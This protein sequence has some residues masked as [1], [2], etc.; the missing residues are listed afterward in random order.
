ML[1]L[2]G[3]TTAIL[4][5]GMGGRLKTKGGQLAPLTDRI[6]AYQMA[7]RQVKIA[8]RRTVA[9]QIIRSQQQ[10]AQAV[11]FEL[12]RRTWTGR[13][14]LAV[15]RVKRFFTKKQVAA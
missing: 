3:S 5:E 4:T 10:F 2:N 6:N 7:K 15:A 11:A 12:Y 14:K 13:Y 1:K 9:E 8:A